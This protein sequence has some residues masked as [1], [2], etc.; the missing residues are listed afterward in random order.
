[1]G[2]YVWL[3]QGTPAGHRRGTGHPRGGSSST[4]TQSGPFTGLVA[5]GKPLK[6]K[7]AQLATRTPKSLDVAAP[8]SSVCSLQKDERIKKHLLWLFAISLKLELLIPCWS[9]YSV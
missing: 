4:L 2:Q 1:M 9:E 3:L 7:P 8:G 6:V 5:R